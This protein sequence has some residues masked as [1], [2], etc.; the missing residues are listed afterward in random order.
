VSATRPCDRAQATILAFEAELTALGLLPPGDGE[1]RRRGRPATVKPV[2]LSPQ[3]RELREQARRR[4]GRLAAAEASA[5]EHCERT[6][7]AS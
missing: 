4:A 5:A 1:C 2:P 7:R 3:A 6:A